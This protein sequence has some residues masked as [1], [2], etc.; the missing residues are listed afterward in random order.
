MKATLRFKAA[1]G[2]SSRLDDE[3]GCSDEGPKE[4]KVSFHQSNSV[5]RSEGIFEASNHC[6]R[7]WGTIKWIVRW[8]NFHRSI[9]V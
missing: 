3:D 9:I 7:P 2:D 4:I 1:S 5:I 8:W 6:F